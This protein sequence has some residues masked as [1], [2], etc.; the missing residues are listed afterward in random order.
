MICIFTWYIFVR[1]TLST[2]VNV[3][4]Y[5][6]ISQENLNSLPMIQC[7][8]AEIHY[9]QQIQS[10]IFDNHPREVFIVGSNETTCYLCY[11]NA[12]YPK[13]NV[14]EVTDMKWFARQGKF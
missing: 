8:S 12:T 11:I 14:S 1:S 13:L 3:T 5:E 4:T 9:E 7:K 10:C 6:G 2:E